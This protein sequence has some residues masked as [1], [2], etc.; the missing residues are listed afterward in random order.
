MYFSVLIISVLIF[1]LA[2]KR[3]FEIAFRM[4]DINGDGELDA[5]E[6]DVVS[7]LFFSIKFFK[8]LLGIPTNVPFSILPV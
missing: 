7:W 2:P 3:Q 5:N 4:F 1:F 6:F 8:Q